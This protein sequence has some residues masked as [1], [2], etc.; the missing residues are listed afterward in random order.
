M[1]KKTM[2]GSARGCLPHAVA[3]PSTQQPSGNRL[4]MAVVSGVAVL[5]TACSGVSNTPSVVAEIGRA[6][7]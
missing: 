3:E 6:H 1:L 5:L 2:Q 4:R 7:V